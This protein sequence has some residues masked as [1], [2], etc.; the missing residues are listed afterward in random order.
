MARRGVHYLARVIPSTPRSPSLRAPVTI[1][2]YLVLAFASALWPTL[3]AVVL[4]ALNLDNPKRLLFAFLVGGLATTIT[5]GLVIVFSLEGTQIVT[6]SKSATTA[7]FDFVVGGLCLSAAF[8][9]HRKGPEWPHRRKPKKPKEKTGP[10][11]TERAMAKG[12]LFALLLGIGLDLV[13][14]FFYLVAL[15]DIAEEDYSPA[16]VVVLV[17]VFCVLMFMLIELPLLSYAV[18]P[19]TTQERVRRFNDWLRSNARRVI[20]TLALVLGV[21]LIVRGLVA[22]L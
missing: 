9:A 8:V 1:A 11:R 13:P 14:G 10:S 18:A 20:P 22:V 4:V 21:L 7:A 17:V 15:K 3:V 19:T 5:V 6:T 16:V 2:E 12:T